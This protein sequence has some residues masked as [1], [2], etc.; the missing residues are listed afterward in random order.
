MQY[1]M[2]ALTRVND[3]LHAGHINYSDTRSGQTEADLGLGLALV[4]SSVHYLLTGIRPGSCLCL[5]V[6]VS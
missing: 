1:V 6:M 2:L 5:D 4:C 3:L